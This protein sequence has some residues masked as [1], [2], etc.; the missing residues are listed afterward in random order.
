MNILL[1]MYEKKI[2]AIPLIQTENSETHLY[3]LDKKKH[4]YLPS[5]INNFSKIQF[6]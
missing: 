2:D 6:S 5:F 3:Q 4:K 1:E